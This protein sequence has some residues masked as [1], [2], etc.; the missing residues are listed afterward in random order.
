[1]LKSEPELPM[2]D[3]SPSGRTSSLMLEET[4]PPKLIRGLESPSLFGVIMMS[5]I[6]YK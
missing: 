4:D 3:I 2:N 5:A 1:M 6:W